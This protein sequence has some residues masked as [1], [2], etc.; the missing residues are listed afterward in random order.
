MTI[1]TLRW[2]VV[3]ILFYSL[4]ACASTQPNLVESAKVLP[5]QPSTT[6]TQ[7]EPT[8]SVPSEQQTSPPSNQPTEPPQQA[9][10]PASS[11]Q[12]QGPLSVIIKGIAD[13]SVVQARQ[14]ELN[15]EA[16]PETVINFDDQIVFVGQNRTF[17]LSLALDEGPNLIEITAS[18]PAGNTGTVYLS[19]TYDP[20]P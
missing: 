10:T 2:L 16:D 17:S 1:S 8:P 9:A 14:L 19:V 15:G 4:S 18:D 6:P 5:K 11:A 13:E 20:Q 7:V 12:F 3:L